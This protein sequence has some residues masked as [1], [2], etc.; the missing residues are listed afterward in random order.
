MLVLQQLD[1]MLFLMTQQHTEW[2]K[3]NSVDGYQFID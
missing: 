3:K 1:F 2:G